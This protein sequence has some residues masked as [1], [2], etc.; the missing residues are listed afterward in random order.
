MD[1]LYSMDEMRKR[2]E[3]D[4]ENE[5]ESRQILKSARLSVSYKP[6]I[7]ERILTKAQ[8]RVV[9]TRKS[10]DKLKEFLVEIYAAFS[11]AAPIK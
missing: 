8:E 9:Y 10:V 5:V 6:S 2:R 3:K 7:P 11:T 4:I 1:T